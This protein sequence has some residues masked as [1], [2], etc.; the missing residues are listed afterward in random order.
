MEVFIELAS[1]LVLRLLG[2]CAAGLDIVF[3]F[4]L[5]RALKCRWATPFLTRLDR[6]GAPLIDPILGIARIPMS[7]RLLLLALLITTCRMGLTVMAQP[8]Q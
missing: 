2:L 3:F 8:F 1:G 7:G 6:V 4:V 5:I